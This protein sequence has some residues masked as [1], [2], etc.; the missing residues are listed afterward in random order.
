MGGTEDG[1]GPTHS[2]HAGGPPLLRIRCALSTHACQPC[3][4][5]RDRAAQS[6]CPCAAISAGEGMQGVRRL[7]TGGRRPAEQSGRR[8]SR[9]TDHSSPSDGCS[10]ADT[11][12]VQPSSSVRWNRVPRTSCSRH[13][14]GSS[15]LTSHPFISPA[16]RISPR[17]RLWH[18][19]D[20][21]G[22]MCCP[23]RRRRLRCLQRS[24]ASKQA[25]DA[26]A[27]AR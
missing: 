15:R 11:P 8:P 12:T 16:K 2:R 14:L 25:R 27:Q 22:A 9:V 24:C 19:S 23:L 10:P 3:A 26:L 18:R 5:S 21:V 13:A 17:S 6:G 4:N 7:P 20:A 1:S